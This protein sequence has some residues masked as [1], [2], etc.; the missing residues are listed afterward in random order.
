MLTQIISASGKYWYYTERKAFFQITL[1]FCRFFLIL[2]LLWSVVSHTLGCNF[3]WLPC[4]LYIG[5]QVPRVLY[6]S[7]KK[8]PTCLSP[9]HTFPLF[10]VPILHLSLG[11]TFFCSSVAQSL[12]ALQ[13]QHE[14]R[15]KELLIC[16]QF[17]GV[18]CLDTLQ[19]LQLHFQSHLGD[20]HYQ[21]VL[22]KNS[23][24]AIIAAFIP[25]VFA[26]FIPKHGTALPA[27]SPQTP[28]GTCLGLERHLECW[29]LSSVCLR[30]H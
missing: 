14:N 19:V 6:P 26:V 22:L 5:W 20:S 11:I 9:L 28:L 4:K 2:F 10:H 13:Q 8:C 30:C 21:F 27:Q 29:S 25:L 3:C 15:N 24:G 1:G 7:S 12:H 23:Q 17:E 18:W 16:V